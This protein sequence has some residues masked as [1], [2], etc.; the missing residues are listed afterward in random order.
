M[1]LK[2]DHP[3]DQEMQALRDRLSRLSE[4]SLRINE[5]LDFNT[6]LQ[7]GSGLG[8]VVGGS[9]LRGDDPPPR[10]GVSG[11]LPQLR[12][13]G[14]RGPA[15]LEPAGG[16]ADLRLPRQLFLPSPAPRS[17]RLPPLAGPSRAAAGPAG[18][19]GPLLSCGAGLLPERAG[20]QPLPGRQGSRGR[21]HPGRRGDSG[22][23]RFP[24]GPIHAGGP[25]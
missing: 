11:G 25:S 8:P 15:A 10:F 20:G 18:G 13:D 14:R 6:V 7:G 23:V 19:S 22:H 9:P 1:E 17:A 3:P 2:R 12:D 21:V 5:S 24:G 16:G 4:A